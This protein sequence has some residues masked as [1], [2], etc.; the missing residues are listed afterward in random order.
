MFSHLQLCVRKGQVPRTNAELGRLLSL[1]CKEP[2][3]FGPLMMSL[4]PPSLP[5]LP[6]GQTAAPEGRLHA[7]LTPR[8]W[9]GLTLLAESLKQVSDGM[10]SLQD[11]AKDDP[12]HDLLPAIELDSRGI[13]PLPL[14]WTAL[15]A[16]E[17]TPD[18]F[19]AAAVSGRLPWMLALFLGV[20]LQAGVK[21]PCVALPLLRC[22]TSA[23]TTPG[24]H[25]ATPGNLAM[26]VCSVADTVQQLYC[27]AAAN[28]AA[29]QAGLPKENLTSDFVP[30]E[31]MQPLVFLLGKWAPAL[32]V[33]VLKQAAAAPKAAARA[34]QQG[35]YRAHV[36][37]ARQGPAPHWVSA[38]REAWMEAAFPLCLSCMLAMLNTAR[39]HQLLRPHH[40]TNTTHSLMQLLCLAAP[41]LA[42]TD[43]PAQLQALLS[44]PAADGPLL[45][46]GVPACAREALLAHQ[47][48]PFE[49]DL[50]ELLHDED[51]NVDEAAYGLGVS[52]LDEEPAAGSTGAAQP[53]PAELARKAFAEISQ[54]FKAPGQQAEAPGTG[55]DSASGSSSG[56][57][58]E[59]VSGSDSAGEGEDDGAA[60]PA[61]S[62]A[63]AADGEEDSMEEG[64][65][66]EHGSV[67]GPAAEIESE[68]EGEVVQAPS[69]RPRIDG[70]ER[71]RCGMA[72][73]YAHEEAGEQRALVQRS[74][75]ALKAWFRGNDALKE[76]YGSLPTFWQE[77][78]GWEHERRVWKR[79]LAS[80]DGVELP[81]SDDEGSTPAA[82]TSGPAVED[83]TAGQAID[84]PREDGQAEATAQEAPAVA[85]SQA[86]KPRKRS[87]FG[88]ANTNVGGGDAG[89][90]SAGA[91]AGSDGVA[92]ASKSETLTSS[93]PEAAA[94][95]PAAKKRRRRFA[96]KDAVDETLDKLVAFAQSARFRALAS[97][98]P[99]GVITITEEA[100]AICGDGGLKEFLSKEAARKSKHPAVQHLRALMPA[101]APA[102]EA[103]AEAGKAAARKLQIQRELAELNEALTDIP[104]TIK[105][106]RAGRRTNTLEQ[107]LEAEVNEKKAALMEELLDVDPAMARM[108][109][110]GLIA[111]PAKKEKPSRK[112]YIPLDEHPD[113]NFMGVLIGARGANQRRIE[114]ETGCRV[115]VRGQ[116]TARPGK[117]VDMD[118]INEPMHVWIQGD[119]EEAVEAAAAKV[120]ELLIP[121]YDEEWK[122]EQMKQV[123]IINGTYKKTSIVAVELPK[124]NYSMASELDK[125][126]DTVG[127]GAA[128]QEARLKYGKQ[129]AGLDALPD[130][131]EDGDGDDEGFKA[132]MAELG[133]KGPAPQSQAGPDAD[134]GA[135]K[136]AEAPVLTSAPPVSTTPA[137]S[138]TTSA[139]TVAA[140]APAQPIAVPWS[141]PS[142]EQQRA[143]RRGPYPTRLR[144]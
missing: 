109:A 49:K 129:V 59:S 55:D 102:G 99:G 42:S 9:L 121:R 54:P 98:G 92:A 28:H 19:A 101:G 33:W 115:S 70:G 13:A 104:A 117:M 132:Y 62:T 61:A 94:A 40:V 123:A 60:P 96:S 47:V 120:S 125:I 114:T 137:T 138:T 113:Y 133:G 51:I 36:P 142:L 38:S 29:A 100:D 63:P 79:F 112:L 67:P 141:M 44:E 136:A 87:R 22:V 75:R 31:L 124:M 8:D 25:L 105:R 68:E 130:E 20:K 84:E 50:R 97:S 72:D 93:T 107:R 30:K 16:P 108:K 80:Q 119:T 131:E 32:A 103:A 85:E 66:E 46:P 53:S 95:P 45:L 134:V 35:S 127:E 110:A 77:F 12:L 64:E 89:A 37:E 71:H 140:A 90:A 26:L 88:P 86:R 48:T 27:P 23:V 76:K 57:D 143:S 4:P 65:V 14:A 74:Y 116:G 91:T 128:K 135:A 83:S 15:H 144:P 118:S 111:G 5:D 82:A 52:A 1:V 6:S 78:I 11:T 24:S 41:L 10:R 21:V 39:Q 34:H 18:V 126:L 17:Y 81:D 69:K 56:E 43:S 2:A 106:M 58:D 3:E 122:E 7:L 73:V 139:T